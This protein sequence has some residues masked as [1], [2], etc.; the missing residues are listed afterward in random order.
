VLSWGLLGSAANADDFD[1][2]FQI[3]NL[4]SAIAQAK[5]DSEKQCGLLV[6]Q[7]ADL[8]S[9]ANE[10]DKA[11]QDLKNAIALNTKRHLDARRRLSRVLLGAKKYK[12]AIACVNELEQIDGPTAHSRTT[13][14]I[15]QLLVNDLKGSIQFATEAITLDEEY[16]Y[17]FYVRGVANLQTNQY[18]KALE[19]F[20]AAIPLESTEAADSAVPSATLFINR[21]MALEA[22]GR[23]VESTRALGDAF[24]STPD[25]FEAVYHY[26]VRQ[27]SDGY[28]EEAA[29]NAARA[30]EIR[31]NNS[32]AIRLAMNCYDTAGDVDRT[33]E[34][35]E[36]WVKVEPDTII[37]RQ[38]LCRAIMK[39]GDG[40][41]AIECIELLEQL[42]PNSD[43]AD[44]ERILVYALCKDQFRNQAMAIQMARE[45]PEDASMTR[46]KWITK[47]VGFVS[48][49]DIV[50]GE[51]CLAEAES[52]TQSGDSKSPLG[53]DRD[54]VNFV[55]KAIRISKAMRA[56]SPL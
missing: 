14:A 42:D 44:Y 21:S 54:Y 27:M 26:A 19:D 16:G 37:A 12:D 22:L 29:L 45:L 49:N 20:D 33:I 4:S 47:A 46:F 11:E 8:F 48:G 6:V 51:R 32:E 52:L 2:H 56:K 17:A 1:T 50:E 5:D 40:E 7:R 53:S 25:S 35:A 34:F 41:R 24:R 23:H 55:R 43:L 10:Y 15:L 30:V 28:A 38:S 3:D 18:A 36:K 31:P 9:S 13:R 39:S